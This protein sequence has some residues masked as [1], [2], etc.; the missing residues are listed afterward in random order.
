MSSTTTEA[1]SLIIAD[2]D[3]LICRALARL[4]RNVSG[5]E[6]VATASDRSEVLELAGW[7]NPAVVLVEARTVHL[8][9][10]ELTRALTQRFPQMRVIVL[11]VYQTLREEAL[12]AGACRFLLKDAGRD[13]LVEAI[14][15]AAIGDCDGSEA[16]S[17][18]AEHITAPAMQEKELPE[19]AV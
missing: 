4:F 12:G 2:G 1:I 14:R 19:D 9:G 7:L 3:P 6:V 13:T 5:L 10:L 16:N 11:S 8:D 18:R 17:I 15:L